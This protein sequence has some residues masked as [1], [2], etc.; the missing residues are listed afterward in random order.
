MEDAIAHNGENAFF[1]YEAADIAM[2]E[3]QLAASLN[4]IETAMAKAPGN[5]D[6]RIRHLQVARANGNLSPDQYL[7]G[8]VALNVS[9]DDSELGRLIIMELVAQKR[10]RETL[11]FFAQYFRHHPFNGGM[12]I[13]KAHALIEARD[14]AGAILAVEHGLSLAPDNALGFYLKSILLRRQGNRA[15]V[16]EAA[17]KAA[18][19]APDNPGIQLN[20][21]RAQAESDEA[22]AAAAPVQPASTLSAKRKRNAGRVL[23][24]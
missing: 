7:E 12:F 2:K 20:L 13:L 22:E 24:N 19:L 1:L 17:R 5:I 3:G 15:A 14:F 16:L 11:P 9:G 18:V 4:Y 10:R 21:V 6:F 23:A 8:L